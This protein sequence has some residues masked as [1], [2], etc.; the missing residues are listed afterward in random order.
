MELGELS[1]RFHTFR[2]KDKDKTPKCA[3]SFSPQIHSM[4]GW[5]K[6][7]VTMEHGRKEGGGR[8]KGDGAETALSRGKRGRFRAEIEDRRV[9][10]LVNDV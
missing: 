2:Q 10:G 7:D 3:A 8:G 5:V 9:R 6:P 1:G 4:R